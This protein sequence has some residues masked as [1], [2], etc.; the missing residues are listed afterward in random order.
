MSKV[1][2]ESLGAERGNYLSHANGKVFLLNGVHGEREI[3]NMHFHE[4]GVSFE[5]IG[6]EE[7]KFLSYANGKV[8]LKNDI[9][10]VEKIFSLVFQYDGNVALHALGEET[11]KCF[12]HGNG[13]IWLQD[14]NQG[15]GEVWRIRGHYELDEESDDC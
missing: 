11:G 5:A 10:Q 1:T 3:W 8:S 6:D 12:S 15:G 4:G 7:G 13:A 14:G 9:D 2:I